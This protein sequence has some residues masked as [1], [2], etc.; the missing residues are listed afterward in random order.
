MGVE[1][2]E[3]L[4]GIPVVAPVVVLCLL[5][6]WRLRDRLQKLYGDPR[7]LELPVESRL[8]RI[9][10]LVLW[11]TVVSL[12]F[13]AA[14][15]PKVHGTPER[16]PTGNL[17][18]VTVLDVSRSMAAEDYRDLLSE[19][20]NNVP[21]VGAYGT[22]LDMAKRAIRHILDAIP[23]SQFGLVK[24]TERPFSQA[25]LTTDFLALQYVLDNWVTINSAPGYGSDIAA[26]LKEALETFKR[27]EDPG[28]EKVIVLI[29]DGGF[30]GK[31]EE[32]TEVISE[33][34]KARI[35]VAV[36]GLGMDEAVPIPQYDENG[37]FKQYFQSKGQ[38]VMTA[39]EAA[40]LE[41]VAAETGGTYIHVVADGDENPKIDWSTAMGGYR[42]EVKDKPVFQYVAAGAL[43]FLALLFA[44]GFLSGRRRSR[45]RKRR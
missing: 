25:D 21:P 18:V 12:L 13:V 10:K 11:L 45:S 7:L 31:L 30:T 20:Q 3:Y 28:K 15:G 40:R 43:V 23:G 42:L 5:L 38:V 32:L 27:D 4:L 1:H 24:Y 39:V 36:V 35:R 41:Q 14:A 29:S 37:Q 16:V 34:R 26:G 44:A 22:R 33:I 19:N 2:P 17:Q 8:A 9:C 6:S